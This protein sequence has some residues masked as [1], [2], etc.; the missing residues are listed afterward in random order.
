MPAGAARNALVSLIF[1]LSAMIAVAS[2]LGFAAYSGF[3]AG[4][5][6]T[7]FRRGELLS[8]GGDDEVAMTFLTIVIPCILWRA[9]HWK[10]R[11]ALLE[12]GVFF[13]AYGAALA[14]IMMSLDCGNFFLTAFGVGDPYLQIFCLSS[15]VA[16]GGL[17]ASRM[18]GFQRAGL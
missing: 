10:R 15:I 18:T 1:C 11:I 17:I 9:R 5:A 2:A 8:S 12:I 3:W 4:P 7:P 16:M 13:G 14:S 6:E